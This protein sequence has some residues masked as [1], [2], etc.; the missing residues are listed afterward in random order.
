MARVHIGGGADLIL[1][2][3]GDGTI[4]EVAEGM[5][6]SHVP[7]GILPGGTANVLAMEMKL[8]SKLEHAA[9]RLHECRPQRISMGHLAGDG[10]SRH[11]LLMAGVGLDAHIV[12]HVSAPLKARA[13]KFA[14]WVAGWSL[15]GRRLPEFEVEADGERRQCSFALLSK[16]RN[17]GGDFEIARSVTLLDDEFELVLL[18]GRNTLRYVKYFAGMLLNNLASM[19]GATVL[20]ADRIDIFGQGDARIAVQIDGEFAGHLPAEIRIVPDALTLLIPPAY[21]RRASAAAVA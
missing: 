21:S 4:N 20:R 6:H 15:L 16:V 17:Y 2:A 9:E 1:V 5:V 18:E 19:N 7:L 12:Y 11:F 3:G 8:G 14:Y 13:G 10:V